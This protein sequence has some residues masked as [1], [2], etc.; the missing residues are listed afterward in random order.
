MINP[1]YQRRGIGGKLLAAVLKRSDEEGIPIFLASSAESIGLYSRMGFESL[2]TW[3][4][5]NEYW[6]GRIVK[7]EKGLG[8]AG[9]EGLEERFRGVR[10]VENV[11]V[12]WPRKG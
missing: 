3:P 7:L 8:I 2:G 6:A 4:I 1:D 10:E 12:R 9:R 11:M 5:D